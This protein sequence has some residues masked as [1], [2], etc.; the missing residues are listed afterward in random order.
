MDGNVLINANK[1]REVMQMRNYDYLKDEYFAL[2]RYTNGYTFKEIQ[3][4]RNMAEREV[5]PD[6]RFSDEECN[7][8]SM[9]HSFFIKK[10]V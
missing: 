6:G 9:F 10:G 3:A 4:L 8:W 7:I 5:Y 2:P 1:E